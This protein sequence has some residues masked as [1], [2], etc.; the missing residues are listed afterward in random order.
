MNS[1]KEFRK[2]S[3]DLPSKMAINFQIY[4]FRNP[5][6]AL[7]YG[8]WSMVRFGKN[9]GNNLERDDYLELMRTST[10]V[11]PEEL[12]EKHPLE[13]YRKFCAIQ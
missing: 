1:T 8:Y 6:E 11:T 9:Q 12:L 4:G 13:E 7:G 2:L 5:E 3:L 10:V